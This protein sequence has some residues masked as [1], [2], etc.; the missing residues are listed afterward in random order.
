MRRLVSNICNPACCKKHKNKLTTIKKD[1][2]VSN[3]GFGIMQRDHPQ[4]R[5][6]QNYPESS[7]VQI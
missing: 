3:Q 5:G 4:L 1:T 7:G 6:V 2:K